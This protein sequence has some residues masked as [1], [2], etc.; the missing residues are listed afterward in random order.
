MIR[1][2]KSH[3]PDIHPTAFIHETAEI[4]GKV[5]IGKNASIWPN[6]VLR[7]DI[8]EI[9]IGENSNI[10]DNTVIHTDNGSPTIIG[11]GVSVGH[12][13]ILHSCTIHDTCIIGMGAKLLEGS[14][15][16]EQSIVGAG[17]VVSPKSTISPRSVAMGMPARNKRAVTLEELELIKKNAEFYVELK[18][19]HRK[20]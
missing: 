19:T 7:G 20:A 1:D 5:K 17:A 10:Q 12:S 9:V 16:N 13:A 18:E 11:N 6:C 8:E 14:V 15:I 2:W 4:I 3:K